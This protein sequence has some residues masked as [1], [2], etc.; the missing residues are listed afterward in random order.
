LGYPGVPF[1]GTV[2]FNNDSA[3]GVGTLTLSSDGN[4]GALVLEG[5]SAV[6]V[7]NA[8]TVASTT[9]NNIVGNAAGLTFS[10]NWTLGGNLLTLGAGGTAG[11]QTIISGAVS[12]TAGLTLYNSGTVVL[13]GVNTYSGTTSINSPAV[14]TI[15]GAGQ[16]GSGSYGSSIVNGGTFNYNS[17]ANQ[18][19]SGVISGTGKLSAGGSGTLTLSAA[20]TYTGTT[21]INSGATLQLGVANGVNSASSVYL[22]NGG[23]FDLNSKSDSIATLSSPVGGT[24]PAGNVIN[25]NGT[26]TLNGASVLNS[27][28]SGSSAYSGVI[29]G[30]GNLVISGGGSHTLSGANTYSGATTVSGGTLVPGYNGALPS[31]SALTDNSPG[32]FD[33]A[34][35]NE[36][37]PSLA[38]SG[39]VNLGSGNLT[40]GGSASTTFSGVLQGSPSEVYAANSTSQ[41]GLWGYYYATN[42]PGFTG[43]PVMRLDATVNFSDL[44]TQQPAGIHGTNFTVRWVGTL[45]TT[46]SAGTYT[47]T[48]TSDDG[49]RLWVNGQLVVNN[50]AY[51]G[52]TARSGTITLAA[53]TSY[54]IRVEY[55]QGTGGATCVLA[56]T[57]PGG[58]SA[59]IPNS[60]LSTYAGYGGLVKSGSSTLT[61]AG[62]NTYK[63]ATTISGGTLS[64][65]A[66]SNLGAAPGSA[67]A[68]QLVINGGTLAATAFIALNANRG[69]AL[70]PTSGSG[71]G[72]FDVPSGKTLTYAGIVANNGGSGAL[73][74]TDTGTLTLSGANT[75]SG[76]T[77]VNG[78][79]LIAQST[80]A[81][82]AGNAT[83]AN[84]AVLQLANVAALG[85]GANLILNATTP[86]AGT[87]NLA[88]TGTQTISALYFGSTQKAAGTWAASGATHNNAAFTGSGILN[89]TTGPASGTGLSLTSGSNP[90]TYGSSLTFTAT[91]TGNSPGGTVQFLIDGLATGSP[92]ALTS[93]SAALVISTLAVSGSPHQITANYS[94]DDNNNPSSTA[95]ALSQAVTGAASA[96]ALASSQNPSAAGSNVT[97]TATVS[98][99]ADAPAGNVVFLANAVPFSTNALVGGVAAASTAAL[100]AGTNTIAAQYAAQGN[101]LGSTNSLQQVVQSLVACSQTNAIVG[102][103][104]NQDGTFTLTFIGTPQAQYYL[105]ASP[106]ASASMT[107]WVPLAGSTNTVT[108]ST[109][110]WQL[111]LTNTISQQ[112]YRSAAVVPCQ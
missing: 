108:D 102:I 96:T 72:T 45:L 20:N 56:W 40:V 23:T 6:T 85:S 79:T 43:T 109:G 11:N 94:G 22:A 84:G 71:G 46:S 62:A 44:T 89:V 36:T 10:G 110:L 81:L 9:T 104:L 37:I 55:E 101:Y 12:G 57:P 33:L 100:P 21:T 78:G 38:G 52:A 15:G 86:S 93:G 83:V 99:G 98:S 51:Q 60:N 65:G 3:F 112:Y 66:D 29:S 7:T 106:D 34:S 58:S 16:L 87:V 50:W 1:S 88:F 107:N 105:V 39:T 73:T 70:G 77:T 91:V 53:N 69:I 5:S 4:G 82:G 2:N 97:F 41:P 80:G 49:S 76:G 18:T 35:V 19:L 67:R 31:G 42:N 59:V 95:S 64:I 68:G 111:I 103:S 74:K 63:G 26:L 30:S 47:I 14:L 28:D 54:D 13:S 75:Y 32:I 27:G 48:T 24:L 25:N 17:T 61:L 90:S 92:V 8:V